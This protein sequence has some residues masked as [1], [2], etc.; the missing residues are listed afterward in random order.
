MNRKDDM[1]L[2]CLHL[3]F[4]VLALFLPG[5]ASADALQT[6]KI[7]HCQLNDFLPIDKFLGK[8][9]S[10]IKEVTK[11]KMPNGSYKYQNYWSI[12]KKSD[13]KK[14]GISEKL[15]QVDFD[16]YRGKIVAIRVNLP[17][18]V[19]SLMLIETCGHRMLENCWGYGKKYEIRYEPIPKNVSIWMPKESSIMAHFP[20]AYWK[21]CYTPRKNN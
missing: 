9:E 20:R 10:V 17:D 2:K 13:L 19:D 11:D 1:F 7:S 8:N 5:A 15:N 6:K 4:Y 14:I 18:D 21:Q 16:S 12:E 3:G